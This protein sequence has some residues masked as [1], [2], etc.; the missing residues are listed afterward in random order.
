[1]LISW[2]ITAY[3]YLVKAG[4]MALETDVPEEY[5]EAVAERL[6]AE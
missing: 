1:M 6:I 3:T 2:K 4:R 5:R